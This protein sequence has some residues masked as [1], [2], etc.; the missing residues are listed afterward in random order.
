MSTISFINNNEGAGGNCDESSWTDVNTVCGK[1]K[2]IADEM[3]D[4][5]RTC[6]AYC[7]ANG[8]QCKAAWEETGDSC[9]AV[10]EED[11][12]YDFG[13]FTSDAICECIPAGGIF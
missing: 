2:V 1:C 5:Y 4:K 8:L 10:R 11:C 13:A 3:D 9:T 12:V 7:A 6:D